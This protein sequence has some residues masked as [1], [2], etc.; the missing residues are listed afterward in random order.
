VLHCATAADSWNAAQELLDRERPGDFN[1]AV[2]ELGATTCLPGEPSCAQCPIVTFCRTRGTGELRNRKLRQV[3]AEVSFLLATK[4]DSVLLV[5]R[6]AKENLMPGMWE[7]PALSHS[8]RNHEALFR[9]RHSITVTD[10]MVTVVAQSEVSGENGE[11][12]DRRKAPKLPLT[13]LTKKIL[14]KVNIIQ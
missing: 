9:L 11:W 3:K 14:R 5:Q 1:Q 8:I 2:M 4:D 12:I 6:G 7:L 13:G 10:Y